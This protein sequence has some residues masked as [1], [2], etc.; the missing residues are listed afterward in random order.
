MNCIAFGDILVLR[1][2]SDLIDLSKDNYNQFYEDVEVEDIE[3]DE[4]D[5]K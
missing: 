5:F 2:N 3:E 4:E 1:H